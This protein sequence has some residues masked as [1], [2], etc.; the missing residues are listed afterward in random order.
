MH[1][2]IVGGGASGMMAAITAAKNGA[3]V[4][5]LEKNDKIGK[6]I[7]VTG[8]GKCN[9]SNLA[10]SLDHYYTDD[11][12]TLKKYLDI[13]GV[14]N[15]IDFFTDNGMLLTNRDGYLYPKC[16]QASAVLDILRYTLE[17]LQVEVLTEQE[18]KQILKRKDSF[19]VLT[20]QKTF[21]FDRVIL[22]CGNIAGG[23]PAQT[24]GRKP[25][26]Y[27]KLLPE[28]KLNTSAFS[29]ALTGLRCNDSFCKAIAGV[30][31]KGSIYFIHDGK[32]VCE[33]GEIQFTDYGISG[34]PV[35][36]ISRQIGIRLQK[37]KEVTVNVDFLDEYQE[38]DW[39][40]SIQKRSEVLS[41]LTAEQF[42]VGTIHKKLIPV[43][44]KQCGIKP[45]DKV[46]H[47][48]I[49]R[50]RKAA[51]FMMHFPMHV[52]TINPYSNAQVCAGGILLSEFTE[53]LELKKCK[54]LFCTGE[55]LDVD[56]KCG[57]Y[58]LQWAWTSGA[59]AGRGASC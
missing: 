40:S 57:G 2:G 23:S 34:I 37:E 5:I 50:I 48:G 14:Q 41:E 12:K 10:E 49:D 39:L 13:F 30:R 15:T 33:K 25:N 31:A 9:L 32:T 54:G 27:L 59:I 7:L 52:T 43:V 42:F 17:R 51:A 6:K 18:V 8:N 19:E 20:N 46:S 28:I 4:T 16:E 53:S 44:L 29:P 56:G 47:I 11:S 24:K 36:Q 35:F 22:S 3:R 58:N 21:H 1:I 26:D 38:K 45:D 55:I